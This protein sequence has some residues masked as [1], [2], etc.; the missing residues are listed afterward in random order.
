MRDNQKKNKARPDQPVSRTQ[1]C[2]VLAMYIS[3]KRFFSEINDTLDLK[4]FVGTKY[5]HLATFVAE[6]K[7]YY[8]QFQKLPTLDIISAEVN[9]WIESN[10]AE[11]D[12]DDLAEIERVLTWAGEMSKEDRAKNRPKVVE[13]T[14]RFLRQSIQAQLATSISNNIVA[15]LPELLRQFSTQVDAVSMLSSTGLSQPF[16]ATLENLP[17]VL[18]ETTGCGYFDNYMNGGQAAGEVYG[19]AAPYGVCKTTVACQLAVNAALHAQ[20]EFKSGITNTIKVVYFITYEEPPSLLL[21]R[22]LSYAADCDKNP[23]EAGEWDKLSRMDLRNYKDYEKTRY[24]EQ[25]ARKFPVPGE[26]DRIRVAK[27]QL[28]VNLR[29]IDFSGTDDALMEDSGKMEVGIRSVIQRDQLKRGN[30]GVAL[31]LVD[32][33]G[34]AADRCC[35]L[36]N[37]DPDR[38]LRQLIGRFPLRVGNIIAKPMRCPVWAFHQLDTKS[39]SRRPGLAPSVNDTSEAKN[40]MENC[41]FGFMVGTK[42]N[43]S[44]AVLTCCKQRRAKKQPDMVIHVDGQFSRVVDTE[45]AYRIDKGRIISAADYGKIADIEELDSDIGTTMLLDDVGVSMTRRR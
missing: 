16:P 34:A 20:A 2:L 7:A 12:T 26:Y 8:E 29:I 13:Y 36:Q 1:L 18:T 44:L 25:L 3:D 38:Q 27:D 32:Y 42:T 14:R 10:S 23:I 11:L 31:L 43:D 40:F 19:F 24:K 33:V 5:Y 30:P 22:F 39:N 4:Y 15:D 35:Q 41:V 45:G 37:R 17:R 21:P 6:T 9:T 28:N